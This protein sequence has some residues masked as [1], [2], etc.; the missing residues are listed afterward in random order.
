MNEDKEDYIKID[1][2]DLQDLIDMLSSIGLNLPVP[3]EFNRYL[4][5]YEDD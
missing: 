1:P 4:D 5:S 3:E 2:N